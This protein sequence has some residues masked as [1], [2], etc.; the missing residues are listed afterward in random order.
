MNQQSN[1]KPLWGLE[2]EPALAR[3]A[4]IGSWF[5]AATIGCINPPQ[6]QGLARSTQ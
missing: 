5:L 2:A 1:H 3:A 4:L 6:A